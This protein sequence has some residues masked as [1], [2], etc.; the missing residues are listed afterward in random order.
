MTDLPDSP[1]LNPDYGYKEPER[2][3]ECCECYCDIY[4]EDEPF[5]VGNE[6]ICDIQCLQKYCLK[7]ATHS[8]L[9]KYA[10]ENDYYFDFVEDLKKFAS[11]NIYDFCE[12]YQH[13]YGIERRR[14]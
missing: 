9:T 7:A 14:C 11:A 1:L 6:D 8:D 4:A 5:E 13:E 10:K 2:I 12:W 3:G